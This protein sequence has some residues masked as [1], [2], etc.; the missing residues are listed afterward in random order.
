M[1]CSLLGGKFEH[2]WT[3]NYEDRVSGLGALCQKCLNQVLDVGLTVLLREFLL[4][5]NVCLVSEVTCGKNNEDSGVEDL[6]LG[7]SPIAVMDLVQEP[8][9]QAAQAGYGA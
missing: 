7:Q 9:V 8:A 3:T 1:R 6:Q 4:C 2:I 5:L